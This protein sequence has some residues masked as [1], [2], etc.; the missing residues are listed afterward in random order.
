MCNIGVIIQVRTLEQ[1]TRFGCV[2]ESTVIK[3][4][5]VLH[6]T[7]SVRIENP[8]ITWK[9]TAEKILKD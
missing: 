3:L 2:L 4:T 9:Q 7:K 1:I 6:T 5:D 8:R